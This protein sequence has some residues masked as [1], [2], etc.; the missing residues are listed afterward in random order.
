MEDRGYEK[1]AH[2]YDLFDTKDNQNFF[3]H[4]AA[5]AGEILDIGA[6]TGRIAAPLAD[7]GV[8]VV[9]IEPSPAMR[10]QFQAKLDARPELRDRITLIAGDAAS[11]DLR[12]TFPA[13]FLSG[14]FDHFLDHAERLA[15]LKNI[16]RH[17]EPGGALVFDAFLGLMKD[18]PLKPA[19]RVTVG[20]WEYRRLVGTRVLPERRIEATL[21]FEICRGGELRERIEQHSWAGITD[22]KEV[23]HLL[24]EAGFAIHREFSDYNFTPYQEGDTLLVVEAVREENR[25]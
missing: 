9:C 18:S 21:V 16:A 10:A 14:S 6:G 3:F 19:G 23:H 25:G 15:S 20:E 7:K 5:R 11:F 22:R 1:T 8:R 13:A 17:L 24:A 2:L 12:R 4:Y